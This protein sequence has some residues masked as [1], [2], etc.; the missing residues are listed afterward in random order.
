MS[1]LGR[2]PP[3]IALLTDFGLRDAYVASCKGVLLTDCPKIRLVD[4][5]HDI[6]PGNIL[7][8]AYVLACA[9]DY[10][11]PGAVFLAVVDPGVGTARPTL[12]AEAGG[13]YLIAPDN[14]TVSCLARLKGAGLTACELKTDFL[15][16]TP[17]ATFH[18]RDVFAP[19]AALLARGQRRLIMGPAL[20]P[21][22]LAQ[23]FSKKGGD[24]VVRGRVVHLD[25]FG[26]AVTS[27]RGDEIADSEN[28]EIEFVA[29]GRFVKEPYRVRLRGVRRTYADVP[30]GQPLA[31][32]G[33][34]GFLEIGIRNGSAAEK[35]GVRQ[36]AP[37]RVGV[38]LTATGRVS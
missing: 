20:T 17:S 37:V 30:E 13:R 29:R 32:T 38:F 36:N 18:G 19:A 1:R 34:L 8:A 7:S 11:P 35:L 26:N 2:P 25:R 21:V 3:L 10:F 22:V 6:S 15:R 33:S 14:G 9:W 27:I 5:T 12:V 16:I 31:Y 4:I 28:A 24:Q 23:A